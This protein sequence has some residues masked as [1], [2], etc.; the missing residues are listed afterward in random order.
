MA[1]QRSK[2]QED[3]Q[4][5]L[6]RLL[7]DNPEMSQRDLARAVNISN[8]SVHYVLSE[9]AERGLVKIGNFTAARDKRRYA[10]VL[11]PR[12]MAE[13]SRIA[14]AVLARKVEEYEMLKGEIEALRRDLGEEAG[15]PAE[16]GAGGAGE[17]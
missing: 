13:K 2:L 14:R 15:E 4:F 1:G 9:L 6:M 11:T 17:R 10:Y 8:G 7:E 12:G 5:R 16:A 3:V